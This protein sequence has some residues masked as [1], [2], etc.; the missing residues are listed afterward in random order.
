VNVELER[1]R[2]A[3]FRR[4]GTTDPRCMVCGIG[5]WQCLE[6]HHVAGVA[7]DALTVILC[8]NCHRM[9]SDPGANQRAPVESPLMERTGR[10]LIGLAEFLVALV[11]SLREYGRQ[12]VEGALVSP[13]PYGWVGAP[14]D[15][16]P[17]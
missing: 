14:G 9:L 6:L 15:G 7:R 17:T 16:R 13:W 1:R 5:A 8:R 2:Q 4:L 3:A 12:L 10:L 11:E